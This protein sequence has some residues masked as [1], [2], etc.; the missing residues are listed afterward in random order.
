MNVRPVRPDDKDALVPLIAQFRVTLAQ[1]RGKNP[2]IDLEAAGT[3]L[4]EYLRKDFPVFVAEDDN[5]KLVGYL[6]CRVVEAVVW[7]ESLFVL[8][9]A[10]RRG[11]GSALYQQAERLVQQ[12]GG[13]TVYNWV[14]PNN[15]GIISFLRKRGCSVLNLIEIRRPR[16]GEQPSQQINVGRHIFDY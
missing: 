15:D 4:A 11:V 8:P 7:A 12:L 3:E 16:P 10:R 5:G 1:F 6:V 2:A 14:H 13:D 9:N